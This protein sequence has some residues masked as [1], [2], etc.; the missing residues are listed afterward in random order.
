[1]SPLDIAITEGRRFIDSQSTRSV[2]P[3]GSRADILAPMPT[4]L[5]ATA[6]TR[7]TWCA[8]SPALPNPA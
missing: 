1:M 5:P 4:A 6:W 7:R 2:A 8:S 3:T